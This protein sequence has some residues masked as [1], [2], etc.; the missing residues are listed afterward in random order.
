MDIV[1]ISPAGKTYQV[2]Q[3]IGETDIYRLREC[4]L[5]DG[6]IAIFKAAK[7]AE[8]NPVLDREAYL[9]KILR[10]ESDVIEAEFAK[11][12]PE[13]I[14]LNY[15]FCFPEVIE[16]FVMKEQENRRAIVLGFPNINPSGKLNELAPLSFITSR[17]QVRV[18]PRTSAW[19]LGKLLKMLVFTQSVHVAINNLTT[20]NILINREQHYVAVFDW[21][22]AVIETKLSPQET[23]EEITA[24]TDA[25]LEVLGADLETGTLVPDEQMIDS[26]Y[27]DL[28]KE[29]K[30]GAE[31]DAQQAHTRF[32]KLIKSLWPRG[33]HK[34]A[35]YPL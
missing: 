15:H 28:L 4:V 7:K 16:T 30:A 26:S 8:Y 3:E 20:E 29:F 12:Y 27:E 13:K 34:F 23:T 32:Y 11:K 33:F 22:K 25:V 31:S 35:T 18:D 24:V 5:E 17:D 10:S 2:K 9:L 21:S 6:T 1:I 14:P 19:I